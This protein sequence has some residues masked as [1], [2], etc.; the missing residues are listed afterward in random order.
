MLRRSFFW[1]IWYTPRVC[2]I[3][4]WYSSIFAIQFFL[5]FAGSPL[6]WGFPLLFWHLTSIQRSWSISRR[7]NSRVGTMMLRWTAIKLMIYTFVTMICPNIS[8]IYWSRV[9]RWVNI[10]SWLALFFVTLS[11]VNYLTPS[12]TA[13]K[14]TSQTQGPT[15]RKV[16]NI[17]LRYRS[18]SF[19]S[20]QG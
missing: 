18:P 20:E 15:E 8:F 13:L 6:F 19:M 3:K 2:I 10:I 9:I 17:S 14:L 1:R 7:S 16:K 12:R 5:G 4:E 11:P